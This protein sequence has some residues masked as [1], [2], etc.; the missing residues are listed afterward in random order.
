MSAWPTPASTPPSATSSTNDV[1][2]DQDSTINDAILGLP[3]VGPQTAHNG[4]NA[5]NSSGGSGHIGSGNASGTGNQSTT[6]FVQAASVDSDFALS[7]IIGGTTN[8]G[9]GLANSGL[10]LG[11]GN[12][13]TN[14]AVLDQDADGAGIVDNNG[15]ATNDS[16]G[17][18]QIGDPDCCGDEITPPVDEAEDA[19]R[20][21]WPAPHGCR[22]RDPGS[23]RPDAPAPRLR[24]PP[25]QHEAR[26]ARSAPARTKAPLRRGLRRPQAH[27]QVRP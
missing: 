9:V 2:L 15:E 23:H 19:R 21:R 14:R 26:L 4:G 3:F 11:V 7:N 25:A 24:P 27:P 10:N 17:T 5:A 6:D 12:N 13:S 20:P 1:E 8:V 16:D 18:A 22:A